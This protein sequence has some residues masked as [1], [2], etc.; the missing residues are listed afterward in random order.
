MALFGWHNL[1]D[2]RGFFFPFCRWLCKKKSDMSLSGFIIACCHRDI[3]L[4]IGN[5]KQSTRSFGLVWFGIGESW[6]GYYLAGAAAEELR[7]ATTRP[8]VHCRTQRKLSKQEISEMEGCLF[9]QGDITELSLT[10]RF[11][12]VSAAC[13]SFPPSLLLSPSPLLSQTPRKT[14]A[15]SDKVMWWRTSC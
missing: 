12:L 7:E 15:Q 10:I 1:G 4:L 13:L 5:L 14:S 2:Q 3:A 11:P 6:I 9:L 8:Q